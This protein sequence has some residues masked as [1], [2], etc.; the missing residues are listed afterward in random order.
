ME[1]LESQNFHFSGTERI[2]CHDHNLF[3]EILLGKFREALDKKAHIKSKYLRSSYSPS[4]NKDVVEAMTDRTRIK[5][6]FLESRT[7][8]PTMSYK[9]HINKS[10]GFT[11]SKNQEKILH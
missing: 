3:S 4:I 8:E 5:N 6:K 10:L 11:Y 1:L 7:V 9:K 2:N